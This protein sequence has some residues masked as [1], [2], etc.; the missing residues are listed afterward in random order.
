[1]QPEKKPNQ[2]RIFHWW[3][4]KEGPKTLKIWKPNSR[5]RYFMDW[6]NMLL[7][8]LVV[9][10]AGYWNTRKLNYIHGYNIMLIGHG[11]PTFFMTFLALNTNGQTSKDF[12]RSFSM[13]ICLY[14]TSKRQVLYVFINDY[15]IIIR[16]FSRKTST[17]LNTVEGMFHI[18][19]LAT[20][21]I[22]SS[23]D[24]YMHIC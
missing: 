7:F 8:K 16:I 3:I 19:L 6:Q 15:T 21:W 23:R 10:S 2:R 13:Q 5:R 22:R 20:I 12:D 14:L 4:F 24:K 1:L 9:S 11:P 18:I 17:R